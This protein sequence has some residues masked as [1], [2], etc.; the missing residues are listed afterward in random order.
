[1]EPWNKEA[2]TIQ[3]EI[4]I[5]YPEKICIY[6]EYTLSGEEL[7]DNY[8]PMYLKPPPSLTVLTVETKTV[9]NNNLDTSSIHKGSIIDVSIN[10]K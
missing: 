4:R 10:M 5:W 1:M 3:L 8:T 9:W 7:S 2:I 6:Q